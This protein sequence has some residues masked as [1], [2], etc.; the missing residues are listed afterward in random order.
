MDGA[1]RGALGGPEG[2]KGGS[3]KTR[4]RS[5]AGKFLTDATKSCPVILIGFFFFFSRG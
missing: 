5:Q 3:L 4:V 2:G 1:G